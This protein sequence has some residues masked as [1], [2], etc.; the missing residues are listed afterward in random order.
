MKTHIHLVL[1]LLLGVVSSRAQ[2]SENLVA[3]GVPAVPP[4][5]KS[6]AGRY[7]EFRGAAFNSW[8]PSKREML[9]TTRF[10]DTA[11]LHEVRMPGGARRQLTFTPE[12]VLGGGWQPKHGRYIVFAQDKGGGEFYQYYRLD[13]DTG[14]ITLLTDGKSRNVSARFTRCGASR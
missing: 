13:P 8:H 4:E 5:L 3:D 6:D 2:I 12:P 11:Q 10:A 1:C 9:I 7:L 14:S